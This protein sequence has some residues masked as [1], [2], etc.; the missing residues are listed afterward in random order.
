MIGCRICTPAPRSRGG[1]PAGSTKR[2]KLVGPAWNSSAQARQHLPP[3]DRARRR[4]ANHLAKSSVRSNHV[5]AVHL[6]QAL[7]IHRR[8][9]RIVVDPR[10]EY[11]PAPAILGRGGVKADGRRRR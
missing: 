9:L 2:R 7:A 8:T 4:T 3:Y 10:R 11:L 6:R 5:P 1:G